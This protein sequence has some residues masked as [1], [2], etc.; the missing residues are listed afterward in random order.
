MDWGRFSLG[1]RVVEKGTISVP[2]PYTSVGLGT[3]LTLS[4]WS[5]IFINTA[6]QSKA[7]VLTQQLGDRGLLWSCP[8][9]IL[10]AHGVEWTYQALLSRPL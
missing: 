9:F 3:Q 2:L 1:L 6:K 8:G 5:T 10:F 7:A 4:N